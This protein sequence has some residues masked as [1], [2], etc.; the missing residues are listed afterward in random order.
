MSS[1]RQNDRGS[2]DALQ[3]Q[4]GLGP[5]LH[6][7]ADV[8]IGKSCPPLDAKDMGGVTDRTYTKIELDVESL[9][10]RTRLAGHCRH[11]V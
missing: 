3:V 6:I 9:S 10:L 5:T 4:V 2:L 11:W 7:P 1:L 8:V